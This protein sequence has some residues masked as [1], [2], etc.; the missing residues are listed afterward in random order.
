MILEGLGLSPQFEYEKYRTEYHGNPGIGIVLLDETPIGAYLEIEGNPRSIDAAAKALGFC[1]RDY[2]TSSY[3]RLY[4]DYC[5]LRNVAPENMV[6][7]SSN[8]PERV[9]QKKLP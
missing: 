3:G 2:I 5:L 7:G 8:R 4:N 9:T 1:K 6:F